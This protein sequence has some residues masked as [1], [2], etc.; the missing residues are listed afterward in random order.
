M[1]EQ[2]AGGIGGLF[3]RR[4]SLP[5]GIGRRGKRWVSE[6]KD[7]AWSRSELSYSQRLLEVGKATDGGI[8]L[9]FT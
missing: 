7:R 6:Q 8:R 2:T 4:R 1:S 5:K 9:V 3:P